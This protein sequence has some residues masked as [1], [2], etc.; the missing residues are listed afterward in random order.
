M[1]I[2]PV[3]MSTFTNIRPIP[4]RRDWKSPEENELDRFGLRS[5]LDV[6]VIVK[7]VLQGML[8]TINP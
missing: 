1:Y 5:P 6:L 7:I 8:G 2:I 3:A 4:G